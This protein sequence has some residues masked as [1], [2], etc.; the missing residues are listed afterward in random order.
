ML[1]FKYERRYGMVHEGRPFILQI[2]HEDN[3]HRTERH[4]FNSESER[5]EYADKRIEEATADGV[6]VSWDD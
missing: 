2:E 4:R 6:K 1:K 3:T 5:A